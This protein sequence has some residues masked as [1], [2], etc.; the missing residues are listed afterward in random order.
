MVDLTIPAVIAVITLAGGIAGTY[1][2]SQTD[3][4]INK[5]N[6]EHITKQLDR[7]ESSLDDIEEYIRNQ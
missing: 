5:N 4:A 3:V 1:V 2:S 6:I 7:V